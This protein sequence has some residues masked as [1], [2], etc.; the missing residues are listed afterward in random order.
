MGGSK[1]RTRVLC[2]LDKCSAAELNPQPISYFNPHVYVHIRQKYP[3]KCYRAVSR[4][5]FTVKAYAF[6]LC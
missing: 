5:Y 4:L 2:L 1:V 3:A 6:I